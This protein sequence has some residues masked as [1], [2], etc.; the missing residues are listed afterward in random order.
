MLEI[1]SR[2]EQ[3]VLLP[4]RH[5]V[6]EISTPNK[7][8]QLLLIL[9]KDSCT[10]NGHSCKQH[11]ELFS[12]ILVQYSARDVC[13]SSERGVIDNKTSK[14]RESTQEMYDGLIQ[15]SAKVLHK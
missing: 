10:H 7:F 5:Q 12:Q 2:G 13:K 8:N 9:R 6:Q 3:P 15:N 1:A 14:C 11:T 4:L